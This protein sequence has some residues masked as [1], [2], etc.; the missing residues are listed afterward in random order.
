MGKE[1]VLYMQPYNNLPPRLH[2]NAR[3]TKD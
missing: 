2:K 1:C 3:G